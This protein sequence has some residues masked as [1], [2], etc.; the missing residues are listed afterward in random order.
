MQRTQPNYSV[1]DLAQIRVRVSVAIGEHDE[2]ITQEHAVYLAQTIPGAELIV[3]PNVS[4]FAPLQRP[5]LFNGVIERF[6]GTAFDS[7]N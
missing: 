1:D 3:L 2:F 4:H 6:V 7:D 5:A